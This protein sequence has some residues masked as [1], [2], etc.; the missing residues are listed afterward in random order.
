MQRL[1][2]NIGKYFGD[3]I[4]IQAVL[5][6]IEASA[7]QHGWTRENFPGHSS[8]F[9][10]HRKAAAN[11]VKPFHLYIPTGIHGDEPAGPLA[12]AQLMKEKRWHAHVSIFR[13]HLGI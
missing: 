7:K 3:S 12:V 1:G 11:I 6:E 2:K 5:T 10:L 13:S 8:L 4:E 9:A